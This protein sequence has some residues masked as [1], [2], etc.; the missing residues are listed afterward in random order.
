MWNIIAALLSLAI[1]AGV[2]LMQDS[3]TMHRIERAAIQARETS[4]AFE[5]NQIANAASAYLTASNAP[6]GTTVS[7]TE[8]VS[9]GYLPDGFSQQGPF[10]QTPVAMA[11]NSPAGV[12]GKSLLVYYTDA[13]TTLGDQPLTIQNEMGVAMGIAQELDNMEQG[14]TGFSSGVDYGPSGVA[15]TPLILPYT[16]SRVSLVQAT[17]SLAEHFPDPMIAVNVIP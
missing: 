6:A 8:L 16:G 14:Q 10:G 13:P 7:V 3:Q 4:A 12:T 9:A 15:P 2:A 11:V 1:F 17:A 5:L